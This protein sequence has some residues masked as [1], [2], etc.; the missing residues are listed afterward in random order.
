MSFL[1]G[2]RFVAE[3]TEL[4]REL[5]K[6]VFVALY[7]ELDWARLRNTI[8]PGDVYTPHSRWLRLANRMLSLYELRPWTGM[9]KRLWPGCGN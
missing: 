7:E 5:R 6:E 4:T 9:H 8:A 3:E 1:Y 2:R